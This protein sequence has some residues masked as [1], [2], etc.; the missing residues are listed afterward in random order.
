MSLRGGLVRQPIFLR[1]I[2]RN[3]KCYTTECCQIT[4]L[5]ILSINSVSLLSSFAGRNV[6]RQNAAKSQIWA[7]S[8]VGFS[9]A[10]AGKP[11]HKVFPTIDSVY[12]DKTINHKFRL[13]ALFVRRS[14]CYNYVLYTISAFSSRTD[15]CRN[16][17]RQRFLPVFLWR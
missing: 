17:R 12:R 16:F 11:L 9:P 2:C 3:V 6:I 14:E 7:F 15:L 8:A 5:G 4:D 13:A 10:Q 1:C